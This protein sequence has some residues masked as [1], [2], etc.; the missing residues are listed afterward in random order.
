M[1]GVRLQ[2]PQIRSDR[3][4]CPVTPPVRG[5]ES[6]QNT[7]EQGRGGG[8]QSHCGKKKEEQLA[9]RDEG[10]WAGT[11]LQRKWHATMSTTG[12]FPV[13]LLAPVALPRLQQAVQEVLPQ[14]C[15]D[16]RQRVRDIHVYPSKG[17]SCLLSGI[18]SGEDPFPHPG[19]ASHFHFH[20]G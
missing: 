3:H 17:C 10:R 20:T 7:M 4:H 11:I 9:G 5:I 19:Q 8:W 2:H 18:L 6:A 15:E 12:A 13:C 16:L 1:Q 14:L